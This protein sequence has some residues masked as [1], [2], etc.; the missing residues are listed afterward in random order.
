VYERVR[1]IGTIAA[2][3]TRPF[4]IVKLFLTEGLM[5]G[6]FG[7]VVGSVLSFG[8]VALLNVVKIT[9][10]F[11]RETGLVLSPSLSV[12]EAVG[13]GIIVILIS[14]VASLSPALRASR[15]DP[16]EALRTF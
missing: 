2:M 7:A 14:L 9:Y 13:A 5:L 12:S 16:V 11:G 4:T 8:L 10:S 1:E 6:V 3:G 15:L